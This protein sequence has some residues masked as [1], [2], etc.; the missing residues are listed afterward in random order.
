MAQL[1][2]QT[3]PMA[4][5]RALKAS[6]LAVALRLA[7]LGGL[8]ATLAAPGMPAAA[9]APATGAARSFGIP[10]GALD[11]ALTRFA[12]AAGVELTADAD[13]LKGRRS[14]G[15][16]GSY[17]VEQGFAQLLRGQGLQAQR[18]TNGSYIVTRLAELTANGD[19]R[20]P[21]VEVSR[22]R[23]S[24]DDLPASLAGGQVA[25]GA[26]IGA[27]GNV[28]LAD[29]PFS[30]TAYT[31]QTIADQQSKTVGEVLYNDP[32]V[33][34]TTSDGHNAENITIRGFDVNSTEMAFNGMYGLLP[35]AHVPTEFLERVEVFRGPSAMTSGI[36]PSGAVGGVINLVPKRAEDAPLTRLST[37]Y[38]SASRLGVAADLGQR[39]GA[40]KRLGVRVNAATSSGDSTLDHQEKRENLASLGLDYRGER[41][42]LE[43]DAYNS[44]QNQS[45]GSPLMYYFGNLGHVLPA[46]DANKNA[47]RGTYA[48]QD[49]SG[50]VL[51]GEY[52]LD[53]RWS[54][55][56]ALGEARYRYEGYLNGTR[57]IVSGEDGKAS[58]QTFNQAGYTHGVSGEA[59]IRGSF[60]TGPVAH[61]VVLGL[62]SL[63]S[64]TGSAAVTSSAAYVTNIYDPIGSPSLAGATG[65][66]RPSSSNR[67]SSFA[68]ADTLS[69]FD[70]RLLLTLGARQQRV[71]QYLATP[72]AYDESALTPMA[73]IVIK[74]WGNALSLYANYIEGLSPGMTV[75]SVY[76]NEGET[77]APYKTRQAETGLK[78]ARGEFIH[79]LSLF[80]IE[81]PSTISLATGASRPTLALD[82]EQRNQGVEWSVAGRLL[83]A[84]RMLGGVAYT[85][86]KQSRAAAPAN[87]GKSAPGV[88]KWTAN[89]G[90]EWDLPWLPAMTLSARV[91]HTGA[92]YLD[93][94][95]QLQIP[96]WTRWDA[97]AR[98]GM[99]L[100]GHAVVL[101]AGIENLTNKSYWTGRFNEGYA[102]LGEPR[103]YKLSATVD[104]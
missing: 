16:S 89:L 44:T 60:S 88:P 25:R 97:G 14:E 91:I 56:G 45:D 35:G 8:G 54:V 70:D 33:R 19:T 93:A 51:R 71:R 41:W 43:L 32:S 9:Q 65:A 4:G 86:G 34:F 102:T 67:Y 78:W 47:L 104:F 74:P 15:L 29:A 22:R 61:Q 20:L 98:Y 101:R 38:A 58:G 11:A 92:Q 85:Q 62:T 26:R 100:A 95:N 90:S 82:G 5:R 37:S 99:K 66:A 52:A 68:L 12:V 28:D 1:P 75:S 57:V 53:K 84:L 63:Q 87:D 50:G 49:T 42:K 24:A 69:I 55:Y 77:L 80:R 39:F 6:P 72:T 103:T 31:A 36:A 73:G 81:K 27:L 79:T 64:R 40:D 83:P 30:A 96:A 13:L 76:A 3:S 23:L 46:P 48:R 18:Q 2:L 7:L 59:G 94:A 21:T 17:T 10:A